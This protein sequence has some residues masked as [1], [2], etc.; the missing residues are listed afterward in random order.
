LLHFFPELIE[1]VAPADIVRELF[2][3]R[4]RPDHLKGSGPFHAFPAWTTVP[5]FLASGGAVKHRETCPDVNTPSAQESRPRTDFHCE[6]IGNV[7]VQLHGEKRW[8]LVSPALSMALRPSVSRQGRAFF[9]SMLDFHSISNIPH[10]EVLTSAGDALWVPPWMWHRV[11]Y[12]EGSVALAASLFHFR[13]LDF[14]KN[15]FL[16][17]TLILPNLFQ[18]ILGSKTE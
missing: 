14:F 12:V 11:D 9:Y 2:G 8:T 3:D 5:M 7:A 15:N 18:E 17:A 10:Y 6:P 1:E 13:P 4:F 16:F